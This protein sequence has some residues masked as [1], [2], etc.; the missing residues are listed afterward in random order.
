MKTGLLV[1]LLVALTTYQT[2]AISG[3]IL[4]QFKKG[5]RRDIVILVKTGW[6]QESKAGDI[7]LRQ[8]VE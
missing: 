3:L 4:P 5:L 8:E 7:E 1:T 6:Y 2:K